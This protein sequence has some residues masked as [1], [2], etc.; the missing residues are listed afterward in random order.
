MKRRV[1]GARVGILGLG[2]IGLEVA[3]RLAGFD[4]KIAYCDLAPKDD[5]PGWT[6]IADP[7]ELAKYADFL[8]VT[9]QM[10]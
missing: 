6:Y 5:V 8:F 10:Y 7:V 3:R 4:T 9:L 1:H 2:R